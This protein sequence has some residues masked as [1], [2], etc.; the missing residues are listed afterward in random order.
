[1][2]RRL[3]LAAYDIPCPRRLRKALQ[4]ARCYAS[5]GQKSVHECWLS[6]PEKAALFRNMDALLAPGDRFALVPLDIRR[7]P[8]LMG[9][10]SAPADPAFL[11]VH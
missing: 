4:L 9:T 1:M 8:L 5:G 2:N 7:E 10:A 11:Y 3:F 6:D